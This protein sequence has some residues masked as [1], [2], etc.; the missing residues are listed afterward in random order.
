MKHPLSVNWPP[1]HSGASDAR[2]IIPVKDAHGGVTI[3]SH[4]R[5]SYY[6][7]AGEWYAAAPAPDLASVAASTSPVGP[8]GAQPGV[9]PDPLALTSA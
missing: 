6:L 5:P 4:G 3:Y 7:L 2:A 1:S 9:P 8:A